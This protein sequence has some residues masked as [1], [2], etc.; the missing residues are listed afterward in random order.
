MIEIK[1]SKIRRK[2]IAVRPS[3]IRREPPPVQ[4]KVE[5]RSREIEIVL[6]LTGVVLFAIAIAIVIAGFNV[7]MG[8]DDAAGAVPANADQFGSCD[9]GPNCVI[10]GETI[11]IAGDTVKIAGM[12][13]PRIGSARCPEEQQ[14][15]VKAIQQL[16]E[17]LN[18]GKV[19]S[20]GDVLEANGTIRRTVLVDGRDVGAAMVSAGVAREYGS[21][22]GW[23]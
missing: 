17:L 10:D 19:T 20:A 7:V 5:P 3:R 11:R 4:K 22:E 8:K 14:L 1:H 18:S 12:K 15:G 13:A 23:C 6:A 21:S 16:T 9:G 2:A